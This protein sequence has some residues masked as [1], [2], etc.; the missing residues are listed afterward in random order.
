MEDLPTV[1]SVRLGSR[2]G[3]KTSSLDIL[4]RGVTCRGGF[5]GVGESEKFELHNNDCFT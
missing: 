3:G 2:A 4:G 1:E 5:T